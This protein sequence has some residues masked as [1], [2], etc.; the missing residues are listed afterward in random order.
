[1]SV[2]EVGHQSDEADADAAAFDN[3]RG[4]EVQVWRRT[5][6]VGAYDVE[7]GLFDSLVEQL[8]AVVELMVSERGHVVVEQVHEVDD[9]AALLG[10]V[11]DV[12]ISGP[13]VAGIDQN[14]LGRIAAHL[15]GRGQ[16]REV[17]YGGMYVVGR[18]DDYLAWGVAAAAGA[19]NNQR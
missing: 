7:I 9:G 17:L 19:Q 3:L 18:Q 13:A 5:R 16:P 6:H 14:H 2:C 15:D 1:M 11:V 8:L 12:C 4:I 10:G